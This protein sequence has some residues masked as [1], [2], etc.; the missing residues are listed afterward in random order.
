MCGGVGEHGENMTLSKMNDLHATLFIDNIYTFC[1]SQLDGFQAP[2]LD[3]NW[4]DHFPPAPVWTDI[5]PDT[6]AYR[7]W[8][9]DNP[10][11]ARITDIEH[12]GI[13]YKGAY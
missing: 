1:V 2:V 6:P 11:D 7:K 12:Y 9:K 10:V 3:P 8:V 4:R 13:E 5:V